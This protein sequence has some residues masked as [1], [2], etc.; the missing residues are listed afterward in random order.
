MLNLSSIKNIF[1]VNE[2]PFLINRTK[3]ESHNYAMK[4]GDIYLR[5]FNHNFII[6]HF[7]YFLCSKT[8]TH[9]PLG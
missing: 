4:M 8:S 2:K 7:S 5:V 1:N 6:M 9:N 3:W